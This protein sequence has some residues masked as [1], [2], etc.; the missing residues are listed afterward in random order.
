MESLIITHER[1]AIYNERVKRLAA[2]AGQVK[3]R[4]HQPAEVLK[5][6]TATIDNPLCGDQITLNFWLRDDTIV[7]LE[8]AIRGCQLAEA[9]AVAMQRLVVG[10]QYAEIDR[11]IDRLAQFLEQQQPLPTAWEAQLNCF[12]PVQQHPGRHDCMLLPF[13][14]VQVAQPQTG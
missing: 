5:K 6:F 9:S 11:K 14:A 13:L 1:N 4:T 10:Q 3:K 2:E 8:F 12:R 7:D